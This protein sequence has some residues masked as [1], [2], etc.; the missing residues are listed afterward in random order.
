MPRPANPELATRILDK[1]ENILSESGHNAINMRTL[2]SSL[3]ITPTTIYNYF[4]SKDGLLMELKLRAA[5][6]LNRAIAQI[7]PALDPHAS[8]EE[9]GRRYV[10]FAESHPN[11]YRLL[12][13][14]ISESGFRKNK[15]KK[16]EIYYT[17][18]TARNAL[19]RLRASGKHPVEPKYGAMTGWIMLH[20]FCSLLI[21][22]R[23]EPAEGMEPSE[24]KRFFLSVYTNGGFD[25]HP[26]N[27]KAERS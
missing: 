18:Y 8:L 6:L 11:H 14:E 7:D 27:K 16:P 9:V 10:A 23:L 24:L 12:F 3:G 25:A 26:L 20:G 1:A 19:E 17:Y 15:K 5:K 2:A 4:E 21:S 13:E 22:G